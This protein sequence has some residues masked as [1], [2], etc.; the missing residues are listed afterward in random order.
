[1]G[2]SIVAAKGAAQEHLGI[3]VKEVIDGGPAAMVSNTGENHF[4]WKQK[5]SYPDGSKPAFQ[6]KQNIVRVFRMVVWNLVIK[7]S[8]LMVNR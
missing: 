2:V 6:V 7:Y 1:M 4:L 8:M 5:Q 3:Y